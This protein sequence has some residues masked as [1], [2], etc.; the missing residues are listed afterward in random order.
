[1][2][3]SYWKLQDECSNNMYIFWQ[4]SFYFIIQTSTGFLVTVI[5]ILFATICAMILPVHCKWWVGSTQATCDRYSPCYAL[6]LSP[7]ELELWLLNSWGMITNVIT[8][9]IW[10]SKTKCLKSV[11]CV[12]MKG[13][14]RLVEVYWRQK[15]NCRPY[16]PPDPAQ[17]LEQPQRSRHCLPQCPR[18]HRSWINYK[19]IEVFIVYLLPYMLHS[20]WILQDE[21]SN[22]MY[23]FVQKSFY[24]LI[25]TSTRFP[26]TVILILFATLS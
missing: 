24:F 6:C 21:C 26:V 12:L 23:I 9:A 20:Y 3:H 25:Q 22:N 19:T 1:M 17:H 11:D 16:Q 15:Y 5:L 8:G 10:I 4:K 14:T 13:M 2:L 18:M 7:S